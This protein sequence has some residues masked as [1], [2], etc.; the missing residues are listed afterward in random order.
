[1]SSVTNAVSFTTGA[2][3]PGEFLAVFGANL[4][5]STV[6]SCASG[7]SFPATCNGT[8]IQINGVPA[9]LIY[10]S[11]TQVNLCAP[12]ELF[13]GSTTL[14]VTT[15]GGTSSPFSLQVAGAAPAISAFT[16]SK[17]A[18]ISATNPSSPGAVVLG[19]AT[20]LG[21]TNPQTT[22]G[23]PAPSNP[24]AHVA[25]TIAVYV[26]GVPAAVSFAVLTPSLVSTYQIAFTVPVGLLGNQPVVFTADG[27]ASPPVTLQLPAGTPSALSVTT[28]S[29]LGTFPLGEI[30][31]GLGASGGTGSYAWSVAIG[32]TLPPGLA[33]RPDLPSY[34]IPFAPEGLIGVATAAGTYN[35]SLSVASGASTATPGFTMKITPLTLM[36]G[37]NLPDGFVG[38]PYYSGGYQL[39]ATKNGATAGITC[40][41]NSSSG[42]SLSDS[43]LISGTPTTAGALTIPATFTDGTDTV[44]KDLTLNVSTVRIT[45]SGLLPNA[46]QNAPY[47]QALAA[48]GGTGPYSY[49]LSGSLPAGLALNG[50]V[51]AGTPTASEGKYNFGVTVTDSA[52]HA[53]TM[54]MAIDVIGSPEGLP[55]IAQY[56]DLGDCSIG[57]GC[58]R[59][60]GVSGGGAAPFTWTVSGLPPGMGFRSGAGKTLA[61]VSPSD[62]ELWGTPTALGTY[63]VTVEVTDANKLTTTQIFPFKVSALLVDTCLAAAGCPGMPNGTVGT[64][65]SSPF[66]IVG[67]TPPYTGALAASRSVP[68]GLPSQLWASPTAVT[69]IPQEG[70]QFDPLFTFTDSAGTANTLTVSQNPHISGASGTSTT[71]N[72]YAAQYAVLGEVYSLQLGACCAASYVWIEPSGTPPPGLSLSGTGLLSGMASTAG[73]YPM[74]VQATQSGNTGNYGTRVLTVVETP[75]SVTTNSTLA[76]ATAGTA[77]SQSL[78]ASGATGS[79]TWSLAPGDLLPPGL[80]LDASSGAISGTPS[81]TGGY[82]FDVFAT[83]SGSHVGVRSFTI[84]VYSACDLNQGGITSLAD[85][86]EMINEALGNAKAVHDLNHDG[87]VNVVDIEISGN[88]VLGLGCSGS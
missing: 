32:S 67:G 42:I 57:T 33:L 28:G 23:M 55:Q 20:G 47:S 80:S 66:R 72:Y 1:M 56:G 59:A 43:C 16:D 14:Q 44:T 2:I 26:G 29:N 88:A 54:N 37:P 84:S 74:L 9:P 79:L 85:L 7:S 69:G 19:Y 68:N 8:S 62:L 58:T 4:A 46:T 5:P 77:Y 18:V 82:A 49:S 27:V 75:I 65:Y 63:N 30:Q 6:D 76:A 50:G 31:L 17:G 11:S 53:Y 73:T 60:I 51:V 52:S 36:D 34:V 86:Q 24:L 22:D 13:S 70:G 83:D 71:V 41:T 61:Y 81:N 39:T 78:A 10:V 35:F 40:T 21:I 64:A 38:T 15:A 48:S 45:T 87:V 12:L 25:A 3:A